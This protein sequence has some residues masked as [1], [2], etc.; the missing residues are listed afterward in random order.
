[1]AGN[2]FIERIKIMLSG[3]DKAKKGA[4]NVSKGMATLASKALAAGAAVAV[5][6][7]SI[8]KA[9]DAYGVQEAAER[10]LT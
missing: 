1:M 6:A 5:I 4:D 10:K 9:T 7:V 8:K 2:T 3:A